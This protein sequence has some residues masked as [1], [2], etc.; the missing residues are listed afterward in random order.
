MTNRASM[1]KSRMAFRMVPRIGY[2][3]HLTQLSVPFTSNDFCPLWHLPQKS[4]WS[5]WSCHLIGSLGHLEDL[6]MQ[7]CTLSFALD[8]GLMAEVTA[9]AFFGVNLM[10]PPRL[11]G[12]RRIGTTRHTTRST[13]TKTLF[14]SQFLPVT[15]ITS[16]AGL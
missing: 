13:I 1:I 10:S 2:L 9:F 6:I 4:P 16:W 14:I 7:P 5:A 15:R 3:W 11:L 12:K 8:M